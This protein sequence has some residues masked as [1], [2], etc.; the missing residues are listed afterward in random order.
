MNAA[1]I[2]TLII[3]LFGLGGSLLFVIL[4]H[5]RTNGHWRRSEIGIWLMFG[6]ANIAA[7]FALL[8]I[9]RVFPNWPGRVEITLAIAALFAIQTWWPS[10]LLWSQQDLTVEKKKEINHDSR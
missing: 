3:S 8:V 6:R 9:N 4:Y 2:A 1:D 5:I 7:L 10:K